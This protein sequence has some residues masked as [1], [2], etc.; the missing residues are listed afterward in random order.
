MIEDVAEM[1]TLAGKTYAL[2]DLVEINVEERTN[3]ALS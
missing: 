1:Y 3:V 2:R